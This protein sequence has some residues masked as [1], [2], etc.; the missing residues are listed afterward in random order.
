MNNQTNKRRLLFML[1]MCSFLVGFDLIVTIPLIPD[2]VKEVQMNVDLGGLLV[3]AYAVVYAVFSPIFGSLSDR[4]GRKKVLIAGLIVFGVATALTGIANNFWTLIVFRVFAGIG[5]GMIEPVAFA[6]VGDHYSYEERGKAIGIVTGALIASSIIGV[7]I[8]GFVAEWLSWRWAF[9]IIGVLTVVTLFMM[10]AVKVD[11]EKD[12]SHDTPVISKQIKQAFS[13]HAVF[14][15]L[16]ATLLYYGALQGMFVNTGVF[17]HL[18]FQLG[19]GQIGL[20]LM[21]AGAGSVLG[22]VLGGRLSDKAGKKKVMFVAVI[23]VAISVSMLAMM[24][25]LPYVILLHVI[26]AA[27]YGVGQSAITTIISELEPNSRGTIMA[28]NSSAMYLGSGLFT[29]AASFVLSASNFVW[30]GVVC[31]FAN[32]AVLL[33]VILGIKEKHEIPLVSSDIG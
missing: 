12:P 22:S 16:L 31:G 24:D 33:I 32:V 15:A 28:L 5:A 1:A 26:W 21:F 27:F 7:P 19:T 30:L 25:S 4:I 8:G 13:V 6:I 2:I 10:K 18:K 14:L 11:Q 3:T 23:F 9:W 29:L 17:Y 20:I